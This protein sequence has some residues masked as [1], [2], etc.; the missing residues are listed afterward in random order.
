M[1]LKKYILEGWEKTIRFNPESNDTL[2][3]LPN[4]Y[5]VPSNDERFQ[6]MYYWDTYFINRGL[7]ISGLL[8]QAINNTENMFYLIDRYGFMPNGNRTFYLNNSQPPFLS[9]MVDDIYNETKDKEWLRKAVCYLEKEHYFWETNRKTGIGLNQYSCNKAGAIAENKYIGF[10]DR[11][12]KRPEGHS[13]EDLSCQYI[14]ICESGYDINPRWGFETENFVQVELNALLYALEVN[15]AKFYRILDIDGAQRW[16]EKAQIRK[17]L[18]EKYMLKDGI[19][20]DYNFKKGTISEIFSGASYYPMF[21]GMVSN[22]QAKALVDN[23]HRLESNYGVTATEFTAE[24]YT[25][26]WQAPNGWAPHQNLVIQGLNKYGYVD[27]AKRI[28]KK[29]TRLVEKNY[30]ENHNLWEK[31]NVVTGG[32]D[33]ADESSERHAELPP[34]L[35]WSAAVY[36]EAK[37]FAEEN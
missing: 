26:Q 29:Y 20:N 28:A 34:M 23:L 15:L 22:E 3:G 35:G 37:K 7:I 14:T 25:Y 33:I 16:D 5:T 1:E 11:I 27:D 4:P 24:E 12:G 2:I 31:Y 19:F 21:V 8:Q 30:E 10:I 18:M 9:L 32:I 36:L 17:N 13:D 6:E